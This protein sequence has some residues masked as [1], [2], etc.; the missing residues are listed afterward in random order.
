MEI[1]HFSFIRTVLIQIINA[2]PFE[3]WQFSSVIMEALPLFGNEI[4]RSDRDHSRYR[5]HGYAKSK[6]RLIVMAYPF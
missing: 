4:N 5:V 1:L 2:N 3:E 6:R